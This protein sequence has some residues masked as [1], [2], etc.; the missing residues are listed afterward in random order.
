VNLHAAVTRKTLDGDDMS[1]GQAITIESVLR[2]YTAG[3]AYGSFEESIKGRIAPGM[4][5]DLVVLSAD[6]TAIPSDALLDVEIRKTI[7]HGE[8]VHEA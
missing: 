4:L 6:P 8:T 5:A 1:P 3:G 2:A 7:L